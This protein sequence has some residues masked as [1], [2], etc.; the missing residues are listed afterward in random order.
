M[1]RAIWLIVFTLMV[2]FLSA[3]TNNADGSTEA[4]ENNMVFAI[5]N[6]ADFDFY[7]VEISTDQTTTG[8]SNADGSSIQYGDTLTNEFKDQDDMDLDLEGEAIFEFVL[9]GEEEQRVSLNEITIDLAANKEYSFE[10]T[11]DSI[12]EA[13]INRVD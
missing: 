10:I 7:G 2:A 5:T 8:I 4:N 9:I 3:C 6:H 1:K 12:D 13:S 11:G